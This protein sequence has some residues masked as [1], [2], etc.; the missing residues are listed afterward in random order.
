MRRRPQLRRGVKAFLPATIIFLD[1]EQGGRMLPEQKAYIYAW[2]DGV[3]ARRISR[4]N[5]LFRHAAPDGSNVVTAEDIRQSAGNRARSSTGPSTMPARP[6][7]DAHFPQPA[8][9]CAERR[10]RLPKS[11]SSR[12]RR[13]AKMSPRTAPTTTATETAIRPGRPRRRDCTSISIPRHRPTPPT[14]VQSSS[15]S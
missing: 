11:G 5:L 2:V 9:P 4:W 15:S 13:S 1:Q 8:Q 10:S 12:N 7:P 6:R 14:V 3:I